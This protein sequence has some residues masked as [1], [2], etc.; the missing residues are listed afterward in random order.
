MKGLDTHILVRFLVKDDEKQSESVYRLFKKAESEKDAFF[1]PLLVILETIWVLK[2]VYEI[3]RPDIL[4]A[5]NDILYLPILKFEGQPTLKRFLID[6]QEN[7]ADLSDVLIA[8]SARM[9][10]C[11]AVLSFDRKAVKAGIFEWVA[12]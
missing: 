6:S 5:I 9:S 2:A 11:E 1:V 7:S 10:G 12:D 3:S 4:D 8:C